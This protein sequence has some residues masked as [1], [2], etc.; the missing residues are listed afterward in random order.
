VIEPVTPGITG[1]AVKMNR[2][3]LRAQEDTRE[4]GDARASEPSPASGEKP[5]RSRRVFSATE[6]LRILHEAANG[7]KRGDVE[8]LL[9]RECIYSSHLAA[10]R[11]QLALHGVAGLESAKPGRKPKLDARDQ[12]IL[13]L[14]Q[15][16]QQLES[17]L[18]RITRSA[19]D[20]HESH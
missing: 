19:L 15:K 2:S 3:T 1:R 11:R 7:S 14:E 10:W 18:D 13:E 4:F 12:R 6:K 20:A 17:E 5:K 16:V 9:R 8:A